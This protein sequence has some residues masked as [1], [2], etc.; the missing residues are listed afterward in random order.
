MP[1]ETP[2][3]ASPVLISIDEGVALVTLN[4]PSKLNAL[5]AE[6]LETLFAEF[7]GLEENEDVHCIVITGSPSAKPPSFAAGADIEEMA[8]MGGFDLRH[9]S[10][11][12]QQTFAAIEGSPKPVIAAING[13]AL[14][15]GLELAMACHIRYAAEGAKMGQPE[16]TL[17]IIPGFGGTQRLR[18]L[19][20]RGRALELLL[21]GESIS[22][23][24]AHRLGL[25]NSTVPHGE[26]MG[27]VMALAKKIA[28]NAPVAVQFILDAVCRGSEMSPQSALSLETDLFGL[29]GVTDDVRE[30]MQAF[31]EKRRAAWKGR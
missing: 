16:V 12:G 19:V 6:V 13:F 31:L 15:G 2:G 29:V 1:E 14:G 10:E 11:L 5:S 3:D 7:V 21:T 9:Y 20:G 30:G 17:G 27:V 25:V 22:A 24:Y 23:E 4:R 8:E 28:G 26:L 18:S